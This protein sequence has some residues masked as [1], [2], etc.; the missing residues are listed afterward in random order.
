MNRH[1]LST[2]RDS[3]RTNLA[4][5]KNIG[6]PDEKI[7]A[8]REKQTETGQVN[9]PGIHFRGRK[10]GIQRQ[11]GIQLWCYLVEDIQLWLKTF[12]GHPGRI[13]NT[14]LA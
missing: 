2:S 8:L 11:G 4:K 9:L 6:I 10:V 3:A 7:P 13:N 12:L 1:Y 14:V 5:F